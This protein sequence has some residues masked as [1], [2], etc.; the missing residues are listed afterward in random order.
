MCFGFVAEKQNTIPPVHMGSNRRKQGQD[1][2]VLS[3]LQ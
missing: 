2:Q 3:V 1:C